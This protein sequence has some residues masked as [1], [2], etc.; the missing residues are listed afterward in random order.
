MITTRVM[1]SG[2]PASLV[3]H[4]S[5]PS[6]TSSGAASTHRPFVGLHVSAGSTG[7]ETPSAASP[8]PAS[9]TSHRR[10][11]RYGFY[12]QDGVEA[13]ES[14]GYTHG[15]VSRV[16]ARLENLRLKKWLHMLAHW[17]DF[18]VRNA[19]KLKSRV[20]KG[21]PDALRGHVWPRLAGAHTLKARS[22]GLYASLQRQQPRRSDEMCITLDLPR[23]Y[24]T[25]FLFNADT[26]GPAGA[27]S[28]ASG[29]PSE[30]R[31]THGQRALRN[32][33]RAYAV[34][35]SSIGY[36]QGMA[37]V[38]G[39]LLSYMPE[40]DAFFTLHAIMQGKYGLAGMYSPGLPRFAEVLHVFSTL[41][42]RLLPRVAAHMAEHGLEYSMFTSQWFITIFSYSFSFDLVTRV[43]DA[44]LLEGWKPVYRVSIALLRHFQRELLAGD[45]DDMVHVLKERTKSAPAAEIMAL[46]LRVRITRAEV[47]RLAS[48][49]RVANAAEI[50]RRV[51]AAIADADRRERMMMEVEAGTSHRASAATAPTAGAAEGA[52]ALPLPTPPALSPVSSSVSPATA[53]SARA[54]LDAAPTPEEEAAT[55][56]FDALLPPVVAAVTSTAPSATAS[57]STTSVHANGGV[58]TAAGRGSHFRGISADTT[59]SNVLSLA[60]SARDSALTVPTSLPSTLA[61]GAATPLVGSMLSTGGSL[62]AIAPSAA[63]EGKPSSLSIGGAEDDLAAAYQAALRAIDAGGVAVSVP[64]AGES[65]MLHAPVERERILATDALQRYLVRHADREA[66]AQTRVLGGVGGDG[67][68]GYRPSPGSA[69]DDF[70]RSDDSGPESG[71]KPARR[72]RR[73]S[74]D[75][76]EEAAGMFAGASASSSD[77]SAGG[78]RV[79]R[80]ARAP[81]LPTR[82]AVP[83]SVPAPRGSLS[84]RSSGTR[85]R[86]S[87]KASAPSSSAAAPPVPPS[88]LKRP[89]TMSAHAFEHSSGAGRRD[90]TSGAVSTARTRAGESRIPTSSSMQPLSARNA[91]RAARS[92][93][94]IASSGG[95]AG[96]MT[97]I[98]SLPASSY[99]ARHRHGEGG[100]VKPP[101]IRGGSSR[102]L[103]R[104]DVDTRI[105]LPAAVPLTPTGAAGAP[106]GLHM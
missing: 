8:L 30:E 99:A 4:A 104:S 83:S 52:G 87:A 102:L 55:R 78:S 1:A 92:S 90:A 12:V 19:G 50:R 67:T 88:R 59:L 43:W 73:A 38:A 58:G 35:D 17:D 9:S 42:Q 91:T 85:A 86:S 28:P 2:P 54:I 70:Y 7:V 53:V 23:T 51:E 46:S 14:G 80:Q 62:A 93:S 71:V 96:T 6:Y 89:A 3:S 81:A 79:R 48:E 11:D 31:M 13:Q 84:A 24:P 21:V 69:P 76:A 57:L 44:F 72:S 10:S 100:D 16:D 60:D 105:P 29:L 56:A 41:L 45:F 75:S 47:E 37:F 25:H 22:P 98:P 40:E 63:W 64:S 20:R 5:T 34:Y 97:R 15:R 39:L 106:S 66:A 77:A 74:Y 82:A 65:W 36:C 27:A 33:L 32:V 49:Y 68:T 95:P 103:P 18:S 61:S 26:S 94:H 101:V